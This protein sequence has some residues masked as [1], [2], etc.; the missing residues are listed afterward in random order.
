MNVSRSMSGGVEASCPLFITPQN[1]T[2][3][4]DDRQTHCQT[5]TFYN[6]YP[7]DVRYKGKCINVILTFLAMG[8]LEIACTPDELNSFEPYCVIINL[9][10]LLTIVSEQTIFLLDCKTSNK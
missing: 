8:K 9:L 7:F 1:L 6:M 10:I 4:T 2:F 3:Y 5:L